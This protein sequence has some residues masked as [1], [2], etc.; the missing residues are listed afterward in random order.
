LIAATKT[1]HKNAILNEMK[2][3]PNI[4]I[5]CPETLSSM[6]FVEVEFKLFAKLAVSAAESDII[7]LKLQK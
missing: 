6:V 7:F 5:P 2:I 3:L 1:Q 4:S